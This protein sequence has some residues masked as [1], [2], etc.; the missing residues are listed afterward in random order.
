MTAEQV[1]TGGATLPDNAAP[2]LT[3]R[4]LTKKFGGFTAVNR[5]SLEVHEG[6]IVGL[7]GPNGAGKTTLFN[8][9]SRF[10]PADSGEIRFRDTSIE[11]MPPYMIAHLGMVRTFQISR[12]FSKMTVREN[13]TFAAQNQLGERFLPNFLQPAAVKRQEEKIQQKADDLIRYF[14]LTRVAD[15]YAGALSGGQRK[16][17]EM[18]RALMTDPKLILL[19]E[20]MAGVNPALKQE[21]LQYILDLREKGMTFM[22]VE[23]DI[24]MIMRICDRVL[25]MAHGSMIA[26][27]TPEEVRNNEAVIEAYLGRA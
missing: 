27:G 20:P 11:R 2:L 6:E 16:L 19:D 26:Q 22:V 13:L 7:I 12:V 10:Y 23:H 25:V 15:Q 8:M 14:N 24:D 17:L 9:I 1:R 18:A 3:V 21:L 5:I 4:N